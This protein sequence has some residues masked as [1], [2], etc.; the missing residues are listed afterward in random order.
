MLGALQLD[1]FAFRTSAHW[2]QVNQLRLWLAAVAYT[3]LVELRRL[4]RTLTTLSGPGTLTS[5]RSG[6]LCTGT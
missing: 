2:M 6:G 1:L 3:L 5:T 4:G